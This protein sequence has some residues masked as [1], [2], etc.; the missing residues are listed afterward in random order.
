MIWGPVHDSGALHCG[1]KMIDPGKNLPI[2]NT[3]YHAKKLIMPYVIF[4]S[5]HKVKKMPYVIV[6]VVVQS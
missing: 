3:G 6:V 2:S 4:M 5:C 1:Q